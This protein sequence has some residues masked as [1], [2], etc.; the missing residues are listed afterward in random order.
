MDPGEIL[1]DICARMFIALVTTEHKPGNNSNLH[2]QES[3]CMNC[4]M[5]TQLD[6]MAI[7]PNELY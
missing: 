2:Q 5:F 7:K 1:A 6:I 4:D 3:G